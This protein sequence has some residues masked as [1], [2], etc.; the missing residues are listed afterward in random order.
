MHK[1]ATACCGIFYIV[2]DYFFA[3]FVSGS[4]CFL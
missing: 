4:F 1:N 3:G 2:S